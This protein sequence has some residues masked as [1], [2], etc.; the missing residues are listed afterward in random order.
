MN[1]TK[2]ILYL[3]AYDKR[4]N[5]QSI[6]AKNCQNSEQAK[7]LLLYFPAFAVFQPLEEEILE[8][9]QGRLRR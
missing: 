5:Y 7:D 6:Y 1:I 9:V 4:N 8:W 3:I 2:I